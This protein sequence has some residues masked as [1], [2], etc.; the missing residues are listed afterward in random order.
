MKQTRRIIIA[1]VLMVVFILQLLTGNLNLSFFSFPVN[2]ALLVALVGG[3]YVLYREKKDS[4][5]V[6]CFMSSSVSVVLI[7]LSFL[8][9]L[10][11]ALAPAAHFQH[12]WMFNLLLVLLLA[13]LQ[14][15]VMRYRGRYKKRFYL[16]HIGLFVFV[17]GLSFGAPDT[18]K[19]RAILSEGQVAEYA[20][21]QTGKICS[22]GFPLKLEQFEVSYY[23]NK[24]PRSFKAVISAE[25][26]S[27]EILVNHPWS[28]S[29]KEDI[30][31]VSHGTD[32]VTHQPYCVL[33]FIIQPWKY[34]VHFG[35]ILTAVGAFMLLW[36]KKCNQNKL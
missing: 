10:V 23:E 6:Q 27:H 1:T 33:E 2:V 25:N 11:I 4:K 19:S 22:I 8:G 35:L 17:A 13:N 5:A 12:S 32:A 30:Y 34:L 28:R 7:A 16:T 14:L 15:S 24:V 26:E 20:Y 21:D 18:K 3:T 31:L 36:G 29:W 9:S